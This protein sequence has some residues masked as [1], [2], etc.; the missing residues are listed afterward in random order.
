MDDNFTNMFKTPKNS[1]NSETFQTVQCKGL[2]KNGKR[3]SKKTRDISGYCNVHKNNKNST[4]PQNEGDSKPEENEGDSQNEVPKTK[5]S[6]KPVKKD[7]P[8]TK[9]EFDD[10]LFVD[11]CFLHIPV[12]DKKE[13]DTIYLTKSNS[14]FGKE[15]KFFN[16][17]LELNP[18]KIY[19]VDYFIRNKNYGIYYIDIEKYNE[20]SKFHNSIKFTTKDEMK[21]YLIS[22]GCSFLPEDQTKKIMGSSF[23]YVLTGNHTIFNKI[24]GDDIYVLHYMYYHNK[25]VG[26]TYDLYY[27]TKSEYQVYLDSLKT[28]FTT[29][30][31]L[32]EGLEKLGCVFAD[33]SKIPINICIVILAACSQKHGNDEILEY[34]KSNK[35]IFIIECN[36][37]ID[38]NGKNYH[39][40]YM[41]KPSF[42][43]FASFGNRNTNN[44]TNNKN[45]NKN[46]NYNY[47]N[48]QF[49]KNDEYIIPPKIQPNP[50]QKRKYLYLLSR[51]HPDKI[52]NY[53]PNADPNVF[54]IINEKYQAGDF[55]YVDREYDKYYTQNA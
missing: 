53:Y 52:K 42:N 25:I 5:K 11:N 9:E 45:N 46:N 28:S 17:V 16:T 36:T 27:I 29:D 23:K 2:T 1:Q 21:N 19:I 3:C 22:I 54:K 24:K 30:Q 4:P 55:S 14:Y 7:Y 33:M 10:F 26:Y 34:F 37:K 47:N 35:N 38:R 49:D 18:L 51:L 31:Q 15:N 48:K 40:F 43:M 44:N 32:K 39:I 8:K 6:P 20:I 13:I 50:E 12:Y 41:D